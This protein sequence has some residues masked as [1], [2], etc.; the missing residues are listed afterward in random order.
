MQ[1]NAV[2]L[3]NLGTPDAPVK[4]KV[5]KFLS[6][7]L[8]DPRVIDLPYLA[9][10]ILVNFIIVPFRAGKSTRMYKKIW[11][12]NGSPILFHTKNLLEKLNQNPSEN[13]SYFFA[14]RY[15]EPSIETTLQKIRKEN[16]Q[17]LQ[18]IPLFPQYASS[19]SGSIIEKCTKITGKETELSNTY[20][21]QYFYNKPVFTRLWTNRLK[22]INYMKYEHVLFVFHGLPVRQVEQMHNNE[23]CEKFDCCTQLSNE[24]SLCYQAQCYH[25]SR[26]LAMELE[27]DETQYTVCFQ[28]RFGKKWLSP[29]ADKIIIRKAKEGLKKILVVPLSFVAD[30]LET[31]L[32]IEIEYA[33]LFQ[34]NGGEQLVMAESLNSDDDWADALKLIILSEKPLLES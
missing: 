26:L 17:S 11:T 20:T 9:R 32:E 31:R 4:R 15:G 30:C 22:A 3:V 5:R 18:I 19:T 34:E 33:N 14:M 24:N 6:E 12:E 29:F 10:K 2:L 25:H 28:S 8:N 23:S 21:T 13:F 1:K 27:L 16:Y 7:F